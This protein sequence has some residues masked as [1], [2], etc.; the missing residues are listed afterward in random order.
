M[1]GRQFGTLPSKP[2]NWT[3]TEASLF[4]FAVILIEQ[5]NQVIYVGQSVW[6]TSRS[7]IDLLLQEG[8][9]F[10]GRMLCHRM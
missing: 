7:P 8:L 4:F 9:L 3:M 5:G 6:L 2:P 1:I 10:L